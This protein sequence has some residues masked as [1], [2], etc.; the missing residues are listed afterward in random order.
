MVTS[1]L[2][3]KPMA[4]ALLVVINVLRFIFSVRCS[5]FN[6]GRYLLRPGDIHRVTGAWDFDDLFLLF[7]WGLKLWVN[8]RDVLLFGLLPF[9]IKFRGGNDAI[10]HGETSGDKA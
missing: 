1:E 3:P 10:D 5:F 6:R 9:F 4:A 2:A 7:K 8:D